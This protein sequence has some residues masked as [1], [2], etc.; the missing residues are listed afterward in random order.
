MATYNI[1]FNDSE[2]SND[3]GFELSLEQAKD[4]I[5]KYNGTNESYFA[6]YKGGQVSIIDNETDQIVY[7]EEI[8]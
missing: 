8:F 1:Y 5:K 7:E 2:N 4:Y 6:D 3:K